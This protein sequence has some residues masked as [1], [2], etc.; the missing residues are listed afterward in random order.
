MMRKTVV[1]V[2]A[3]FS[4]TVLAANLLRRPPVAA[5][6]IVLIER[7]GG[8][9]PRRGVRSRRIS[10]SSECA[11]GAT[12]RRIRSDPLQFLR[13]AQA[14]LPNADG[15]DFL[16]RALYGDYLQ[17]ML[18]RAERAAPP[19]MRLLRVVRRSDRHLALRRPRQPLAAQFADR[20][21]ILADVVI[22]ALGNPPPPLPAVGAE[23]RRACARSGKI[24]ATCRKL[25][26][27]SIRCSS[28]ATV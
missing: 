3:G 19:Q 25:S 6:D 26:P 23:V 2:G 18:L 1:I 7:G 14:R 9:G 11:G 22:L 16:P 13:F 8:Y 28:S 20:P 10:L 21:P 4:G 12:H 24:R 5:T 15:E 17:D 27:P